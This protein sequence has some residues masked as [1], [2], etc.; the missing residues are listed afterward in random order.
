ML[1]VTLTFL[2]WPL[3]NS[4]NIWIPDH[5]LIYCYTSRSRI[6]VT[7]TGEGRQNL[8]LCSALRAF[9]QAASEGSLSCHTCCETRPRFSVLPVSFEEPPHLIASYDS[10]KDAD[11]LTDWLFIVLRPAQEYF[12][13]MLPVKGY[14]IKVNARRSGPLSRERSLGSCHTCCDTGPRFFRFHPKDCPIQ[15]PF[16]THKGC[17]ESILTRILRVEGDAED[18]FLPGSSRVIPN[19]ERNIKCIFQMPVR[20]HCLNAIYMIPICLI[21]TCLPDSWNIA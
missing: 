4:H 1:W 6:D 18:L 9:E 17:G 14:K 11:W 20:Y 21:N 13:Y 19:Q 16:T 5:I 12:T 15:S 10:Q 7:I 8:G 2:K 3:G